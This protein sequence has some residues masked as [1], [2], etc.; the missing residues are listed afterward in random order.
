IIAHNPIDTPHVKETGLFVQTGY[1]YLFRINIDNS[2][3]LP[4]IRTIPPKRRQCLFNNELELYYFRYY[5][6]RN[7]EME[8]DSKY[9]L[10]RC[11]C[12][13]YH[14]PLIYQ[15]ASIWDVKDFNCE[16]IA[17]AEIN[18][19]QHVACKRKCLPA[20]FRLEYYPEVY[21]TPL[22]N[23]SFVFK[24]GFFTN[25]T[26]QEIHE[27]F[28]LVQ[29]YFANDF[30]RSKVRSPYTSFTDYLSQ[31]GGILGLM[32]GFGVMSVPEFCYFFLIR[33][34]F[35]F[36]LNRLPGSV[37]K[38]T[39]M[40]IR[41]VFDGNA[42]LIGRRQPVSHARIPLATTRRPLKHFNG[43]T[44]N[45]QNMFSGLNKKAQ[46]QGSDAL[47]IHLEEKGLFPYTE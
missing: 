18:D 47:N 29:V 37:R 19:E 17:E 24:D 38:M 41:R 32:V 20:C 33:P 14:M 39:A 4:S 23:T 34:V 15:N 22:A 43:Y 13:P 28:A 46:M 21:G 3:S 12:I 1:Q 40:R 42:V 9:F 25:F 30:F 31:T 6:R 44:R 2:K 35:D 7:C 45:S 8:C 36:L 11:K 16:R 5:T 26:K 27:N 10:R